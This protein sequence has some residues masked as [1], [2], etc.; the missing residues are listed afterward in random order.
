MVQT[1]IL[2]VVL[3]VVGIVTTISAGAFAVIYA[4]NLQADAAHARLADIQK[5]TIQTLESQMRVLE[6]TVKSRDHSLDHCEQ[7]R[8]AAEAALAAW[9]KV[10][11]E[12]GGAR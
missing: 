4:R 3:R 10:R 1:D 6:G 12:Y 11:L 2:D 8:K 7:Q 5:D 9:N